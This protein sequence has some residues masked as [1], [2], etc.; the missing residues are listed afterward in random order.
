MDT[1]KYLIYQIESCI[2][3]KIDKDLFEC[4]EEE[5]ENN[6]EEYLVRLKQRR[7]NNGNHQYWEYWKKFPFS[8]ILVLKE[9]VYEKTTIVDFKV[10]S[11]YNE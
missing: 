9:E 6:I 11:Y 4:Y 2:M 5:F 7:Y 8:F 3:K 10:K 1:T